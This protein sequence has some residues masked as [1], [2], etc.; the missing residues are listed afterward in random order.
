MT[1][2]I[3]TR[4][5]YLPQAGEPVAM[6]RRRGAPLVGVIPALRRN[7]LRFFVETV[8][9]YGDTV[10][11]DVGFE[12]ILMVS[13][14]SSIKHVMQDNRLNYQKSKFVKMLEPI[15]G[16][17]MFLAEGETWVEQRQT[18][19]PC[20]QGQH[21]KAMTRQ[22]RDAT[23]DMV[24]RWSQKEMQSETI[25]ISQEMMRLA[26]D[27]VLRS[28]FSVRL[29]DRFDTV[30]DSLTT[31]LR[32]T[33]KRFWALVPTPQWLPTG[34]NRDY[35]QALQ[36]LDDFVYG[37]IEE[38]R[39]DPGEHEDLL[40]VLLRAADQ[41]GDSPAGRKILRDQVLSIILAGHDTTANGLAW[42]WILLSQ[43]LDVA[44]KLR[45]EV[46][47]VLGK[48]LVTFDDIPNLPYTRAVFDE[49][50]RLY[51][52]LW[53]YSRSAIADDNIG[54]LDI[55]AGTNVMLCAYAV[56]RRP[57]LWSDPEGFD[58][59]RFAPDAAQKIDRFAYIPFGGGPRRCLGARFATLEATVALAMVSQ[60]FKLELVPGQDL[61][62]E[63][64]ITLRPRGAVNMQLKSVFSGGR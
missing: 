35:H 59:D 23:S 61:E 51:P 19:A 10:L 30:Y 29:D 33:E 25:D 12:K 20:F 57:E 17:G 8:R 32:A 21:L 60:L 3:A 15:L 27:M 55:P 54:G 13:R 26:L 56:H 34:E 4:S 5:S 42:S 37:I 28:L 36:A 52:P 48:R 43:H 45:A 38:R 58:P 46:D 63:P 2:T 47:R 53:T 16:D 40:T 24:Y 7:P 9:D 11:L 39:R 1:T 44:R 62:P 49:A 50:I 18:S 64:M 22:M 31:I 6:Q 41:K 14:P